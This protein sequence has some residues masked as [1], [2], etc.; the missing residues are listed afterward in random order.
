VCVWKSVL[1]WLLSRNWGGLCHA[2]PLVFS[3]L[4]YCLPTKERK[5][6]TSLVDSNG[7][8]IYSLMDPEFSYQKQ[9]KC[10]HNFIIPINT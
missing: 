4:A 8:S 2:C 5:L 1:L 6:E 3:S 9:P 7:I 10:K